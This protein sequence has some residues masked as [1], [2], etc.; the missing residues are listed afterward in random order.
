GAMKKDLSKDKSF[1][2]ISRNRP[3]I[4]RPFSPQSRFILCFSTDFVECCRTK[5]TKNGKILKKCLFQLLQ[6]LPKYGNLYLRTTPHGKGRDN[7]T[8]IGWPTRQKSLQSVDTVLC[9]VS[10]RCLPPPKN[11][12][13]P[14]GGR[15]K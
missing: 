4:P 9:N 14:R 6:L 10:T 11:C 8:K 7:P 1:F 12:R 5:M 2:N 13:G 3:F 15:K